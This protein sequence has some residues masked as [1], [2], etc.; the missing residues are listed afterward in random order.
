MSGQEKGKFLRFDSR[1]HFVTVPLTIIVSVFSV[2]QLV[3]AIGDEKPLRLPLLI[4]GISICL[5]FAVGLIRY[6][7]TKTQ[8]RIIRI[9]EQFRHYRLTGKE[10]NPKLTK[11]QIIALRNAGDSEFPSLCVR[12]VTEQLDPKAIREAIRQWREDQM[13]I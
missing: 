5:V 3:D 8:D 7:A 4:L 11:S 9:E 13:R 6:Y 2:I 1:Y 10:L 12:A